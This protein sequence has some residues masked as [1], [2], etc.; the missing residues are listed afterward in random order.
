MAPVKK[1]VSKHIKSDIK[2]FGHEIAKDKELLKALKKANDGKRK[3]VTRKSKG[4]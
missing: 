4:R 2:D 3:K 1:L